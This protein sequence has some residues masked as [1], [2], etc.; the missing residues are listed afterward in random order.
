M[1]RAPYKRWHIIWFHTHETSWTGKF[2]ETES[3]LVKSRLTKGLG[4]VC[5][6]EGIGKWLLMSMGFLSGM[7]K[8]FLNQVMVM[9]LPPCECIDDHSVV[10]CKRMIFMVLN[11]ILIKKL[12]TY[13]LKK[14]RRYSPWCQYLY[15]F[16]LIR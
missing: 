2:I 6:G 15:T 13:S 5:V 14:K 7:I 11:Y 9:V 1:K 12:I 8:M 16:K 10:Y 3:R 4:C